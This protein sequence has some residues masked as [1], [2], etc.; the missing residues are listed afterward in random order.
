MQFSIRFKD[1]EYLLW[2]GKGKFKKFSQSD[3]VSWI[4][5]DYENNEVVYARSTTLITG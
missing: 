2:I 4:T 1:T 5:V 3:W